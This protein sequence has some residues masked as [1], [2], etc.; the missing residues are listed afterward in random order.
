MINKDLDELIERAKNVNGVLYNVF[1]KNGYKPYKS[2][3]EKGDFALQKRILEDGKTIFFI[4][5]DVYIWDEIK[6]PEYCKTH[7]K[8]LGFAPKVQFNAHSPNKK[9]F[10]VY[11]FH[12][13]EGPKKLEE[14]YRDLYQKMEC[15]P[16]D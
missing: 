1:I 8:R 12:E 6:W 9:T 2:S 11:Y 4:D 10:E 14:W 3:L 16:Y 7:G 15:D 13:D 5:I